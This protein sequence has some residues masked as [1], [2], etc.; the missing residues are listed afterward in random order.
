M[1]V[2]TASLLELRTALRT[3]ATTPEALLEAHIERIEAVNPIVNGLASP[4]YEK[5]REEARMATIQ[6][7][8]GGDEL[9]PLVGIPCTIKEFIG[10]EGMPQTGGVLW[11]RDARAERDATVVARLRAAGAIVM[12]V[13]NIPEG[14][15][16]LETYNAIYGR[17]NNPW[18]PKRTSGG[19]SGGEGALVASGA[20]PFG[21]G[22]DVGGSIRIPAA[23][24]GTV[25]H[26]PT[27]GLVP[28]TGHYPEGALTVDG[29]RFLAVGPLAR[30]VDDAWL[31]LQIIAG[32]DGID[33]SM[34]SYPLGN[35]DNVDPAELVIYPLA[36]NGRTRVR[37]DLRAAI[38]RSTLALQ[39]AGATIRY[40]E[41]PNLKKA[42][43]IW[44]AML[45]EGTAVPYSE[46][47]GEDGPLNPFSELGRM[48]VGT[49]RHTF[50]AVFMCVADRIAAALPGLGKHF[51]EIG[52]GLQEELEEAMSDNGVILHPPYNRPPPPHW[53]AFRTPFAPAYTAIFNVM[54][55]PVTQVPA[56]FSKEGLPLGVQVVG[57]RG[58]DHLTICAARIIEKAMGGWQMADPK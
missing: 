45:T 6:L 21:I 50:A 38:E 29:G 23:F 27:G 30:T 41:F 13:T 8:A 40:K 55:F 44:S 2:H 49:G 37:G 25:G 39:E 56:G 51:I 9:P 36:D 46:I 1:N 12:G 10:V 33:Q 11:R 20:S 5:A 47:L 26:K 14:G 53:D 34:V 24:C 54:E 17:T 4:R 32:P 16:W 57:A 58:Q 35:P 3:G 48:C 18:D 42:F 43:E 15:L 7:A 31:L 19:S 28:N 22:S 52:L